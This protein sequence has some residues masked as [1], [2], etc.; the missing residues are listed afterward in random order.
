V[1]ADR[2]E[3]LRLLSLS[4]QPVQESDDSARCVCTRSDVRHAETFGE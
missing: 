3:T 1:D 4:P 2:T